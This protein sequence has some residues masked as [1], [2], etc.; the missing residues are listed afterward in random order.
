MSYP[1]LSEIQ[2]GDYNSLVKKNP[3]HQE[4][5]DKMRTVLTTLA[6]TQNSNSALSRLNFPSYNRN[7]YPPQKV[8]FWGPENH[9][10]IYWFPGILEHFKNLSKEISPN[11]P[12]KHLV[13][14]FLKFS[15]LPKNMN[16]PLDSFDQ[17]AKEC[18]LSHTTKIHS[19]PYSCHYGSYDPP[20]LHWFSELVINNQ[21][22]EFD[23][24]K[25]VPVSYSG[26][27][28][29]SYRVKT[30]WEFFVETQLRYVT[31]ADHKDIVFPKL[32]QLFKFVY[33]NDAL[34]ENET[35][36]E[37]MKR[38]P[39]SNT[40]EDYKFPI[41]SNPD[42]FFYLA[43]WA[44]DKTCNLS[45]SGRVTNKQRD[46]LL[47][48][49]SKVWRE[50]LKKKP[51]GKGVEQ[52]KR[53]L[54]E[55]H[56][57]IGLLK[58]A[59]VDYTVLSRDEIFVKLT[60]IV[61]RAASASLEV[62]G[63]HKPKAYTQMVS[64]LLGEISTMKMGQYGLLN[65]DLYSEFIHLL[66]KRLDEFS[67]DHS[68]YEVDG[69]PTFD[70]ETTFAILQSMIH[71]KIWLRTNH[72]NGLFVLNQLIRD[73]EGLG[74]YKLLRDFAFDNIPTNLTEHEWRKSLEN[75]M[76]DVPC[77]LF[78]TVYGSPKMV[79]RS[80][81]PALPESVFLVKRLLTLDA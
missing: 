11:N 9:R 35:F 71:P 47:S 50:I 61:F 41:P 34:D 74:L 33:E 52:T 7:N 55:I 60:E 65:W 30:A 57:D 56:E 46:L 15:P 73:S 21:D 23:P 54:Q 31:K 69:K 19:S 64:S 17:W 48:Q 10:E 40:L 28:S 72:D 27:Y 59:E 45:I 77:A 24:K 38:K 44:A 62:L 81:R 26:K 78:V 51:N 49:N 76:F 1:S 29:L 68:L 32:C 3:A 66:D 8:V 67:S 2:S 70:L 6:N 79:E 20:D 16:L 53:A 12:E 4:E 42:D 39:L 37:Y 63:V 58:K 13:A 43:E 22:P 25:L 80:K 36:A 75:P 14:L 5:L 18:A